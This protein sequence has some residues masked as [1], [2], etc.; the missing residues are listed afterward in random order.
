MAEKIKKP[1][2]SHP[3]DTKYVRHAREGRM[4]GWKALFE[5][6]KAEKSKKE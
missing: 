6:N 2:E 5:K 1:K 4:P 3:M